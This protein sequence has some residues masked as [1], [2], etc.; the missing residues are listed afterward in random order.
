M[1]MSLL[2][3]ASRF[4]L[5]RTFPFEPAPL[6]PP[7]SFHATLRAPEKYESKR[8]DWIKKTSL[9]FLTEDGRRI[10]TKNPVG[11]D[12]I[13]TLPTQW[14]VVS[15]PGFSIGQFPF[16]CIGVRLKILYVRLSGKNYSVTF[17]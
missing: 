3:E 4:A 10:L 15:V 11:A 16:Q 12:Q 2:V 8:E 17:S 13:Y 7:I 5:Y 6:P 14:T 9:S 1:E